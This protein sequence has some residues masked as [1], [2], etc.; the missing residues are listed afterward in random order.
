MSTDEVS[1]LEEIRNNRNNFT[2]GSESPGF[3]AEKKTAHKIVVAMYDFEAQE[4]GDLSLKK[5]GEYE[6]I[7]DSGDHWWQVCLLP[8]VDRSYQYLLSFHFNVSPYVG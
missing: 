2:R 7:D 4:E 8:Y 3:E 6:V 5:D 1:S